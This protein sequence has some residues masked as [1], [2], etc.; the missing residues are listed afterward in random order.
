MPR[1]IMKKIIYSPEIYTYHI[2]FN[3]HVSNIA[4]IEWM[5]VGRLRFLEELGM[6]I[7]NLKQASITPVLVKTEISYAK[8]LYLGDKLTIELWLTALKNTSA[9]MEFKFYSNGSTVAAQG[10]QTGL[11]I[12][13][14][15][16]KPHRLSESERSLFLP[17]LSLPE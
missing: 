10:R 7:H 1:K 6:P 2:D 17:Y 5:E 12:D 8:P 9:E 15:S 14:K 3:Q 13:L 4:Y 16:M 11:F